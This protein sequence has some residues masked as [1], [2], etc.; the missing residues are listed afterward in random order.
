[1]AD[2][3]LSCFSGYLIIPVW[4]KWAGEE[5]S[6]GEVQDERRCDRKG[7][8]EGNKGVALSV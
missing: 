1:M 2:G 4:R 3:P 5:E 7:E 6:E 8:S